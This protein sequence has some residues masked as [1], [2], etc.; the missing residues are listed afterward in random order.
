MAG[1]TQ[2]EQEVIY[3][4]KSACAHLDISSSDSITSLTRVLDAI[5]VELGGSEDLR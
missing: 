3:D 2:K 4:F 1:D 5:A